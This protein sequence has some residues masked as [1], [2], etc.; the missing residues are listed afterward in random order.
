M[1][2]D[3]DTT[4]FNDEEI[5]NIDQSIGASDSE[6]NTDSDNNDAN[7]D[8]N[9]ESIAVIVVHHRHC[10]GLKNNLNPITQN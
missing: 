5:V 1:A 10:H 2:D 8:V 7:C 6:V 3:K 4:E 9:T